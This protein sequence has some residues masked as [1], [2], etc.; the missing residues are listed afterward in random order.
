[1]GVLKVEGEVETGR[2]LLSSLETINAL[3]IE[4]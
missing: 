2:G 4:V 1:M 3:C